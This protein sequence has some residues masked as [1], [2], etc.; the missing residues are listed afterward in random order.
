[1][2]RS[3]MGSYKWIQ[4]QYKVP[5]VYGRE[6]LFQGMR[7]GVIV[8]DQ[9]NYIGVTFHDEKS[10]RVRTLHPTSEVEYLGIVVPRK[11]TKSQRRYLKYLEVADCFNSF[12]DFLR[13]PSAKEAY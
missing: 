6:I 12:K 10:N 8:Q 9:G 2:T 1:M 7:K 13:S 4:S 3:S 11:M 5:A